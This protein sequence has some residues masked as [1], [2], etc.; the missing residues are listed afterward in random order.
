MFAAERAP[1]RSTIL[2]DLGL[3]EKGYLVATVHRAENTD[4]PD[5]LRAILSAFNALDKRVVFPVHPRTR[6][7]MQRIEYTPAPHVQLIEPVG[8]LD[9]VCLMHA[10]RMIL[11]DSGGMQKEAYWLKV[12]CVTLRDE[13]EWVETVQAGWNVLVGADAARIVWCLCNPD[14]L[15]DC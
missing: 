6:K 7:A 1:Q 2:E 11:T 14:T 5:R 8:Y 15:G 10:A 3:E 9:M 4:A 12:P 13:T